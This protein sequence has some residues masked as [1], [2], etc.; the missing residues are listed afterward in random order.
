MPRL[1]ASKFC[2]IEPFVDENDNKRNRYYLP[3]PEENYRI[4]NKRIV[5]DSNLKSQEKGFLI[6]LFT[7]CE[8]N[9]FNC[10]LPDYAILDKLKKISRTTL[11]RLKL[12]MMEKNYIKFYEDEILMEEYNYYKCIEIDCNWIGSTSN[13]LDDLKTDNYSKASES[14]EYLKLC[15]IVSLFK[16][17]I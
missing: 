5:D 6:S 4:I 11:Y 3:I 1:K 12:K 14:I 16:G 8:N 2:K 17:L 7:I 13:N 10:A 9:T 15:K